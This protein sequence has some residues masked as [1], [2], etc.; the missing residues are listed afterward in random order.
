[1]HKK[2][3]IALKKTKHPIVLASASSY[4]K[5]LFERLQIEFTCHAADIDEEIA[6]NEKPENA[7]LRLSKQKAKAIAENYTKQNTLIIG[8]D[9]VAYINDGLANP[10]LGKPNTSQNAKA[11]LLRSSGNSIHFYTAYYIHQTKIDKPFSHVDITEVIYR[12]LDD[13]T[14]EDYLNRENALDCAGSCKVEGLGIS[15]LAKV[16]SEDPSAL[17]GLPL[18]ELSLTLNSL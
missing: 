6:A 9:Q 2:P 1:M 18:I 11:Q 8:C 12:D 5:E 7:A 10:Y 3:T 15:L 13:K 14:I 4:K 17:I 16:K